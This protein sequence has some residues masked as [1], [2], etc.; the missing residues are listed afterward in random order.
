MKHTITNLFIYLFIFNF[1][2]YPQPILQEITTQTWEFKVGPTQCSFFP[3]SYT[4]LVETFNTHTH[5]D[6]HTYISSSINKNTQ[7]FANR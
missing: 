2:F 6:T 5:I 3:E 1:K 4:R 7:M